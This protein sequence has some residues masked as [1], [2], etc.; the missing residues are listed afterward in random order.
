MMYEIFRILGIIAAY[1]IQLV[2]FKRRTFCENGNKKLRKIKGGAL[3]ISNHFNVVDYI[4]NLFVVMP[5]KLTVVAAELAFKHA[6]VRFSM[7][8]F[9]AIEAN[10]VSKNLSFID[11]GAAVI[12]KGRLLQIFPEGHNTPDGSIQEFSTSYIMIAHR[13]NSPIIPI[14]GDGN[15]GLFRRASVIIGEPIYLM[16]YCP[17]GN[18]TGEKISQI[19]D[20]IHKKM[21][22]LKN[23]LEE[24]K[25]AKRR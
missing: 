11:E 6:F 4:M 15:Y 8:F 24:N 21:C 13:A 19:N 12:N 2:F 22:K 25:R 7:R 23:E 17:D 1:P 14:V 5:R 16:D 10:R 20:A 9:G 18:M 3:I